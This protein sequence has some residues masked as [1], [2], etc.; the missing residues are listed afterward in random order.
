MYA[1]I[2]NHISNDIDLTSSEKEEFTGLLSVERIPKGMYLVKPGD[3]VTS[4]YYVVK[5]CLR[6]F[7]LD[8]AGQEHIIQFAIED[9][10]ISDFEAFFS[11]SVAELHVE[12]I[13]D[14]VLLGLDKTAL[15]ALYQ[16]IPKFE[17]FFRIKTTG[18]FVALRSRVLSSLQKTGKQRYL[19]FCATYPKIEK[20]IANYHI[21]NYLGLKPESLS[22]IRKEIP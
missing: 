6:A 5:G 22:R 13:E 15:E 2:L 4:E 14:S 19:E 3:I 21:A 12:A 10:W 16:R 9:W 1:E 7:Y 20:R 17:R 18:A 11:E 8:E